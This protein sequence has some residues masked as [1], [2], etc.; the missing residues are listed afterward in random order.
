[1]DFMAEVKTAC[2]PGDEASCPELGLPGAAGAGGEGGGAAAAGAGGTGAAA[3]TA[4]T[5]GAPSQNGA[6]SSGES[7]GCGFAPHPQTRGT[8]L[9][10]LLG[11]VFGVSRAGRRRQWNRKRNPGGNE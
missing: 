1:S 5:A 11:L 6:N 9:G 2:A 7:S 10:L 4:G 3:G 8:L